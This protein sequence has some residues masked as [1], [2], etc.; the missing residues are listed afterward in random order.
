MLN[1]IIIIEILRNS[2][3]INDSILTIN[4]ITTLQPVFT[5]INQ[6]SIMFVLTQIDLKKKPQMYIQ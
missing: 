2:S 3:Y 1:I 6:K 5:L 4:F